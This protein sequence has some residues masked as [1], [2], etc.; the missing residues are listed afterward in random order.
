MRHRNQLGAERIIPY[1]THAIEFSHERLVAWYS[2]RT[3]NSRHHQEMLDRDTGSL[4]YLPFSRF[5]AFFS[6]I[7]LAGFFFVSFFLS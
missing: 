4:R 7:V 1:L 3:S 5:A 2:Q 6:A